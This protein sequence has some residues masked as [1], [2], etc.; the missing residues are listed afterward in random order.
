[1]RPE[2]SGGA[3]VTSALDSTTK[4]L[5]IMS[6]GIKVRIFLAHP[7]FDRDRCA[8]TCQHPA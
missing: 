4:V 2:S 6:L 7:A 3:R 5:E 8:K 1:M